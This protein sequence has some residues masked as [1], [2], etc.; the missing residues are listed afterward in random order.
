M[1]DFL[2]AFERSADGS[3]TCVSKAVYANSEGR[4]QV[5]PGTRF[6]SGTSFMGVDL[7][8]WLER[9]LEFA[10]RTAAKT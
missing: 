4:I 3:W 1:V 6:T 8:E 7:V 2:N 9:Q 5:M 10:S